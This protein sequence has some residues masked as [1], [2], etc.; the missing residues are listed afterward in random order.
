MSEDKASTPLVQ[1]TTQKSSKTV[2]LVA[3]VSVVIAIIV[4]SAVVT[5][6]VLAWKENNKVQTTQEE[7]QVP[8]I[9]EYPDTFGEVVNTANPIPCIF[10][11]T[12]PSGCQNRISEISCTDSG[13]HDITI[14]DTRCQ[15]IPQGTN[16]R[17]RWQVGKDDASKGK[18]YAITVISGEC[19]GNHPT[20]G[21][22][23]ECQGRCGAGCSGLPGGWAA[24]CLKHDICSWYFGA[25]GGTNDNYCGLTYKH[26]S[27]DLFCSSGTPNCPA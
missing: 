13:A 14:A 20:T 6:L 15:N 25:T 22:N 3:I 11:S 19:W 16:Y 27:N 21:S 12:S 7:N 10:G 26:A 24:D 5:P 17:L 1:V 2:T 23:Y 9:A 18:C 8:H 4:L